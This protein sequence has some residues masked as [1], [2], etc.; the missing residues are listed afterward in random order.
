METVFEKLNTLQEIFTEKYKILDEMETLP[1]SISI[2]EELLHRLESNF[3]EKENREKELTS[4][5]SRLSLDKVE[6]ETRRVELEGKVDRVQNQREYEALEKEMFHVGEL[7]MQIRTNLRKA[8][9]EKEE[10]KEEYDES[11][12]L[13]QSTQKELDEA[14]EGVEKILVKYRSSLNQLEKKENQLTPDLDEDILFKFERIIKSKKGLGLVPLQ[15]GFCSGCN[16]VLPIQFVNIVRENHEISFCPYCSRVLHYE[17]NVEG[18]GLTSL[19][20][21]SSKTD[22]L[23]DLSEDGESEDGIGGLADLVVDVD[24]G[25]FEDE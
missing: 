2:Q 23:Q 6:I 14:K 16:M 20:E 19:S 22:N 24:F 3:Q 15:N 1:H 10:L 4:E 18:G 7:A 25:D 13:I 17:S 21:S 11:S 12:E 9:K 5:I 8:E